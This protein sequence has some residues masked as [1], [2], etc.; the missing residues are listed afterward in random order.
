MPKKRWNITIEHLLTHTSGIRGYNFGEYGTNIH[1]DSL[2]ESSKVFRDDPL[3]FK[4]G[5]K[6]NYSGTGFVLLALIIEKVS[7]V[8]YYDYLSNYIFHSI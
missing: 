2:K 7:G 4:P 8:P 3:L 1:Y 5:T 6:Y